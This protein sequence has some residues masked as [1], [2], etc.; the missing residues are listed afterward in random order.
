MR[1]EIGPSWHDRSRHARGWDAD[2]SVR[3]ADQRRARA[4]LR[5]IDLAAVT[6][7]ADAV[8]VITTTRPPS[9]FARGSRRAKWIEITEST[10]WNSDAALNSTIVPMEIVQAIV[11]PARAQ[12]HE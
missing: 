11:V 5:A 9:D 1:E 8:T 10:A 2:G 12:L 6:P 7:S 3:R 4:E